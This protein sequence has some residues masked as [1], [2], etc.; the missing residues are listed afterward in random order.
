[1]ARL[2]DLAAGTSDLFKI[3]PRI[4]EVE[5]GFNVRAQTDALKDHVFQLSE[6]IRKHG[7]LTPLTVRLKDEKVWL[8]DGHCRLDAIRLLIEEGADIETVPCIPEQRA[9]NDADRTVSLLTRNGGKPL[10]P[11]EKAAVFKRLTDVFGW[12]IEKVAS[13]AAL[14]T[15][16]VENILDLAAAPEA[17]KE[18]VER[19]EVSA[20]TAVRTLRQEGEAGATQTLT[21]AV[22]AAKAA[23]KSKA[24]PKAIAATKTP[25]QPKPKPAQAPAPVAPKAPEPEPEEPEEPEA[26][27]P[28][29]ANEA[30]EPEASEAEAPE[31]EAPASEPKPAPVINLPAA[32]PPQLVN[33]PVMSP[34][35]FRELVQTL[36][37]IINETDVKLIHTMARDALAARRAS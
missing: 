22:E 8:V 19:G 3:D 23:G 36:H 11:L 29:Q 34:G 35:K 4:I 26:P 32:K 1:M 7:V 13:Q 27:E 6:S 20:T 17:I 28:E 33:M 24:T 30:E 31:P 21:K 2:K 12:P 16:Q 25:P 14:T 5:P 15:K 9:A 10:E 18:M 37:A